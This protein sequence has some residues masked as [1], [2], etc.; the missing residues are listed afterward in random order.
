MA[1][2]ATTVMTTTVEAKFNEQ[3]HPERMAADRMAADFI[4]LTS[5]SAPIETI[6]GKGTVEEKTDSGE[7]AASLDSLPTLDPVSTKTDLELKDNFFEEWC[8]PPP[9]IPYSDEANKWLTDRRNQAGTKLLQDPTNLHARFVYVYANAMESKTNDIQSL[10]SFCNDPIT[11]DRLRKLALEMLRR[12][13]WH[14]LKGYETQLAYLLNG[15]IERHPQRSDFK[16]FRASL[17]CGSISLQ[18]KLIRDMIQKEDPQSV[19]TSNLSLLLQKL[20]NKIPNRGGFNPPLKRNTTRKRSRSPQR[21]ESRNRSDST[22][23]ERDSSPDK[24]LNRGGASVEAI[25]NEVERKDAN[26]NANLRREPI[27]IREWSAVDVARWVAS[28]GDAYRP[29]HDI[30]VHQGL[31]GEQFLAL[32]D[33]PNLPQILSDLGIT[34][35]FH[36]STMIWALGL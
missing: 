5:T 15:I 34:N 9:L 32:R 29:Y 28:L 22:E 18:I 35:S 7:Q 1:T 20:L 2:T 8:W 23:R 10:I 3:K 19:I 31:T 33:R 12:K 21:R 24:N 25:P 11:T 6:V 36:Q 13:S 17:R 26:A 14:E 16:L 4:P 30:I 27:I